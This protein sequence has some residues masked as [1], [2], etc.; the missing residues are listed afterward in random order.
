[1]ELRL[2]DIINLLFV[3]A[4]LLAIFMLWRS[5]RNLIAAR[6]IALNFKGL[7]FICFKAGLTLSVVEKTVYDGDNADDLYLIS[8]EGVNLKLT[9]YRALKFIRKLSAE[10]DSLHPWYKA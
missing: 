6:E 3:S 5:R 8:G 10:N 1:M 4:A 7:S 2:G 9:P